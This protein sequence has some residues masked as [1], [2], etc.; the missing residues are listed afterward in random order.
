MRSPGVDLASDGFAED[1][2]PSR[3]ATAHELITDPV[4]AM[5][6]AAALRIFFMLASFHLRHLP[7]RICDFSFGRK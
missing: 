7:V 4:R 5:Q 2:E 3:S 6:L 1:G